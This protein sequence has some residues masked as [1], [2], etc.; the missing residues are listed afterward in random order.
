MARYGRKEA[1]M[2]KHTK[3]CHPER[4]ECFAISEASTQSKDL[5]RLHGPRRSSRT[6]PV[7]KVQ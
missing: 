7:L 5:Y 2:L 4:S 1:M 6:I 3:H